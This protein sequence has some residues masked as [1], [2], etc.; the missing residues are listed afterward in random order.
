MPDP[1]LLTT[2]PMFADTTTS[3]PS[4]QTP[5][6]GPAISSS[7]AT[8]AR[9]TAAP[10]LPQ[11]RERRH[12]ALSSSALLM[13]FARA[14][15]SERTLP[16]SEQM[17]PGLGGGF[18]MSSKHV[19][20]RSCP[21]D[22]VPV[23]LGLTTSGTGCSCSPTMPTPS[24]SLFGCR[25]VARMLARRERLKQ[26]H[27]NG[28]GFGLTLGQWAAVNSVELTPEMMEGMLGFPVGWTDCGC[29]ATP[30]MSE[31]AGGSGTP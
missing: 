1:S 3:E 6:T 4:R 31:S 13:R 7:A 15:Y 19:A 5:T 2:G 26:E 20:T 12:L 28:N 18:E 11:E 16:E 29:S 27:G 21:S 14:L 8:R 17:H 24:A 10:G 23:A 25:D 9:R 30:L 22:S